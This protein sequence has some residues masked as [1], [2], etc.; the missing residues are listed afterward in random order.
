VTDFAALERAGWEHTVDDYYAA[1]RPVTHRLIAPLLDAA[2]VRAGCRVLD[3]GTGPGDVAAEAAD[4]GADV[5]GLDFARGMI[6]LAVRLHSSLR[7]II[8]DA[9]S[10][11]FDDATF[12]AVVGNFTFHHIPDQPRALESWRRLLRDGGCL[13][14]AVW[15][16]PA[17]CRM[18]GLFA[19]AV[20]AAGT[21]SVGDLPG[22]PVM[23]AGDEAYRAMLDSAGFRPSSVTTI[24]FT[25]R[26][27]SVDALWTSV[28]A[29]TVRTAATITRE[30]REVQQRIREAFDRLTADYVTADGLVVPVSV[31]LIAGRAS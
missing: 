10:P 11:P 27:V 28:L 9:V 31:K 18:L 8:A 30:R 14:L 4:R 26:P 15:D 7:F 3:V 12:D 19:D 20:A 6:D 16:D 5:I 25:I 21:R 2:R 23:A 29:A 1:C 22:A 17:A 24:R 13:G